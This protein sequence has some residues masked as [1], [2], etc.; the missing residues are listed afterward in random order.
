MVTELFELKQYYQSLVHAVADVVLE[1]DAQAKILSAN[2]EALR[3]FDR[4]EAELTGQSFADLVVPGDR[5]AFD[6]FLDHL[7]KDPFGA[8]TAVQLTLAGS[9][10]CVRCRAVFHEG[11]LAAFL[12]T[13]NL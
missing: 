4:S 1:L 11:E 12:V 13:G 6:E 2:L 9:E 7:S 5:T 10:A 3:L 8:P